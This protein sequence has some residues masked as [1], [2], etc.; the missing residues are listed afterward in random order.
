M[1]K[2]NLFNILIIASVVVT[3]LYLIL[4]F[5]NNWK[6][7]TFTNEN[8][9]CCFYAYYEKNELYKNNFIYFLENGILDNVDYYII[10]NGES[11]VQ[12][13]QKSNIILYKR[14][15]KGYDFG[16]YSYAISKMKKEYDYY[17]FINTSVSGPHLKDN[18]KSWPTYFIEL[19]KGNVKL[20]GT[21]INI[22]SKNDFIGRDLKIMY[23]REAPFSHVQSMFFCI[24]KEYFIHLNK[25]N[26][27]NEDEINKITDILELIARKEFG[28]S[29]E[30]LK[31]G[32]NINC[33]L[34]GYKDLNY[35]KV[36]KNI[37]PTSEIAGGDPNYKNAYFG[38][39]IDKYDVIFFKNNRNM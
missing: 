24:N 18:S 22:Y 5:N 6:Y 16:A 15:N 29:Q 19:F 35:L 8:R 34:P 26:F 17:F 27:F 28:L 7:D 14:A 31:N 20:V 3:I 23:N 36:N 11:S 2:K 1:K 33:I 37:N 38:K 13:P 32:W 21:T 9:M 4:F 12:I 30:A 10:I 25:I 39:T